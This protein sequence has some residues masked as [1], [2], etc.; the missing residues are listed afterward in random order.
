MAVAFVAV[1]ARF[2]PPACRASRFG[3]RGKPMVVRVAEQALKSG[4]QQVVIATDH[5]EGSMP[6]AVR[7]SR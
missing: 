3:Y 6:G 4:A 1:P 2:S 5:Q 7:P